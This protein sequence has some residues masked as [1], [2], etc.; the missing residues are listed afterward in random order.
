MHSAPK[1]Y[2]VLSYVWG[3]VSAILE[4]TKGN[5]SDLQSPSALVTEPWASRMPATV[6]DAMPYFTKAMGQRYLWVDR[7]CIIQDD[8][9][10]KAEQLKRMSSIYANSYFIIVAVDGNNADY[11]LRGVSGPSSARSHPLHFS[12]ACQMMKAPSSESQ[13]NVKEWHKRGWTY[14]ERTL[15]K[16]NIVFFEGTAFWECR[17]PRGNMDGRRSRW[18]NPFYRYR[19]KIHSGNQLDISLNSFPGRTYINMPN[20]SHTNQMPCSHSLLSSRP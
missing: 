4:T 1:R 14:Q 8:D 17:G 10:H 20:W 2:V 12:A 19:S 3:R 18:H 5:F 15:S 6:R 13:F 11:G 7:L 9:R 16:R